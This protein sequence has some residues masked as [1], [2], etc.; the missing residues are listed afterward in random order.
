MI[1]KKIKFNKP[2]PDEILEEMYL[3]N[4]VKAVRRDAIDPHVKVHV[5]SKD[6]LTDVVKMINDIIKK[7]GGLKQG[8]MIYDDQNNF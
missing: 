4:I 2:M 1:E 5:S 7:H 3:L 8:L 6:E